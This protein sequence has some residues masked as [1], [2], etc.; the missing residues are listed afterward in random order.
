MLKLFGEPP[1]EATAEPQSAVDDVERCLMC[2][3]DMSVM[4][5]NAICLCDGKGGWRL[6]RWMVA[7][8][9]E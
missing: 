3:T 1:M 8:E 2:E 7:Q 9:S 5:A 4:P 6:P